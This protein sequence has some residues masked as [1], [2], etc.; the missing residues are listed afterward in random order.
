MVGEADA[1]MERNHKQLRALGLNAD[2]S[3]VAVDLGAGPGLH[4]IPLAQLGYSVLAVDSCATLA[5]ELRQNKRDLPIQVIEADLV[6]FSSHLDQQ[7]D[8]ILC[9]GD[10]LTHL[11][12]QHV[13]EALLAE[14]ADTLSSQGVFLTTFRD[15]VSS[16]LEGTDRFIHVRSDESRSMTCFLEYGEQIVTVHDLVHERHEKG[17]RLKVSSYPKLRLDPQWVGQTLRGLGLD[18]LQETAPGGMVRIQA[19]AGI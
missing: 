2:G 5:G 17:W 19:S 3:A 4:A 10:T 15:Y 12:S 9:M 13:V 16:E 8:A 6:E 11:A 7:A 1:T 14:V 18:V